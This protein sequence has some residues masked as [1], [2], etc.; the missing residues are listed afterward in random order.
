ME[1]PQLVQSGYLARP[2]YLGD[3][4]GIAFGMKMRES[5]RGHDRSAPPRTQH[6]Y[7]QHPTLSRKVG[8]N[9]Q[10]PDKQYAF[11]LIRLVKRFLG[12][13]HHLYL[14][15]AFL[16]RL[17]TFYATQDEDP[18]WIC[19]L[20]L[21]FALGEL[22]T[23]NSAGVL[24]EGRS[25]G[26]T[27]F[28]TAMSLLQDKY[29]TPNVLYVETLFLVSLYS[30][31][32][33]RTNSAYAYIGLALRVSIA[34]GLHRNVNAQQMPAA[35]KEHRNRVW[36]TVH[37]LE[38][39]CSSK[40]GH[41]VMLR[42]EDISTALPSWDGLT[43]AEK[44]EFPNPTI[45]IAQLNLAKIVGMISRDMYVVSWSPRGPSFLQ[46]VHSI[47]TRLKGWNDSLPSE[48]K[49]TSSNT[50]SRAICSLHLLFN[51][52]VI[53][54][55]RPVLFL[56]FQQY[57]K[58]F[59]EESE[60]SSSR[61]GVPQVATALADDCIHAA[62]TINHILIQMW[63]D[64]SIAMFGYTDALILFT[65]TMVLMI[66]V[67]LKLGD[68]IGTR[69]EAETAWRLL[70]E[71]CDYG[72]N[73]AAEFF[74]QLGLL[75]QD[76]GLEAFQPGDRDA[77]VQSNN[78]STGQAVYPNIAGATTGAHDIN[79]ATSS[80]SLDG[81]QQGASGSMPQ[82]G[83]DQILSASFYLQGDSGNGVEQRQDMGTVIPAMFATS[84]PKRMD[85]CLN[86]ML[87]PNFPATNSAA[88]TAEDIWGADVM[89]NN[90]PF[91]INMSELDGW[92][93]QSFPFLWE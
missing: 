76:L 38:R 22:Y 47:F 25:P 67:A 16:H 51:Q 48:A 39:L 52:C 88:G 8:T 91:S 3:A 78:P 80:S 73:A 1:R 85:P 42:D 86:G 93:T 13:S 89:L 43:E 74:E 9:F 75:G 27:Y 26:T 65:S 14:E 17:S 45:L 79:H 53:L 63:V 54:A 92:D 60:T 31:A 21:L 61:G 71:M 83:D 2:V 41:P 32:L 30:D 19:R 6:R 69:D 56:I 15:T 66:S 68:I 84:L 64:G 18:L 90:M 36:W 58:K 49:M 62:R 72:N 11:I 87:L 7:F 4:S 70:R 33:N 46:T 59:Q 40:L 34:L 77:N 37:Y 20:F 44:M 29:E 81:N 50:S 28:L 23:N 35:E 12:T 10:L 5:I 57:A 24:A 82:P 55:T